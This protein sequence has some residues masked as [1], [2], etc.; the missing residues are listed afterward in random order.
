V[1]IEEEDYQHSHDEKL[2]N[3]NQHKEVLS[4]WFKV[5]MVVDF[6]KAYT[7]IE[8]NRFYVFYVGVKIGF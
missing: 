2:R 6:R 1:P 7:F 4:L 3:E 5:C 8:K